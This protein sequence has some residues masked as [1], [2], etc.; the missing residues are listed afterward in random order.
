M[1]YSEQGNWNYEESCREGHAQHDYPDQERCNCEQASFVTSFRTNT[2]TR[3]AETMRTGS[4]FVLRPV[5]VLGPERLQVRGTGAEHSTAS[6]VG[7]ARRGFYGSQ[8]R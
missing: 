8:P 5:R 7:T 2:R 3:R 4:I 6:R 1:N